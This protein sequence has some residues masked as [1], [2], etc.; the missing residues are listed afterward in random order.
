MKTELISLIFKLKH[1]IYILF[2][3][4][5]ALAL[6]WYGFGIGQS[7]ITELKT[8]NQELKDKLNNRTLENK[9]F[10]EDS[11]EVYGIELWENGQVRIMS[12]QRFVFQLTED[13]VLVTDKSF[14]T[15]I[16]EIEEYG[17]N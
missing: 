10:G 4:V 14:P 16:N 17:W 12:T 5:I 11:R 1:L 6:F 13:T 8:E 7:N 2:T 9:S 3:I 15:V